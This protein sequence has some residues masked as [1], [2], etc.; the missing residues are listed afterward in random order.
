MTIEEETHENVSGRGALMGTTTQEKIIRWFTGWKA[1]L[2]LMIPIMVLGFIPSINQLFVDRLLSGLGGNV[3]NVAGQ[4]EWFDLIDE[5]LVA[6][7]IVPMYFILNKTLGKKEEMRERISNT[8]L[9]GFLL[10]A[11]FSVGVFLY[12]SSLSVH[13]N[14]PPDSVLYLRLETIGFVMGF[15]FSFIYVVLVVRGKWEYFVPLIVIKVAIMIT[16]NVFLIPE[17]GV[18]GVA[19][20]NIISNAIMSIVA[21]VLLHRERL[22][23]K[24]K[25]SFKVLK[26]WGRVGMFSGGEIFLNNLIYMVIVVKMINDVSSAG[27]YW[28]ANNFI[29]GWLLIPIIALSEIIR[30]DYEQG[31]LRVR[32]YLQFVLMVIGIWLLSVPLWSIM[33]ENVIVANDPQAILNI[34]YIAMPFYVVYAVSTVFYNIFV[35]TGRTH[36]NFIISIIVNIGYY[37][38]VYG[39]YLLGYFEPTVDFIIMMFG[40]GMVVNAIISVIFYIFSRKK[41]IEKIQEKGDVITSQ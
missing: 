31:Y 9:L 26:D 11:A 25:L 24:P 38:I 27:N 41:I 10:Y 39:L 16:G 5:T 22:L 30:R 4:L 23:S 17:Y 12:A 8:F 35:A 13:M 15:V 6:F 21:L 18:L 37:G 19:Y 20:T 3:I 2:L 7:L 32:R 28:L 14:A 34:L 33:F 36:F 1:S 29:W 40:F